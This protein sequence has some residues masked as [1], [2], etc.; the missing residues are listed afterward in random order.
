MISNSDIYL[1]SANL[2][3]SFDHPD[4]NPLD[5]FEDIFANFE[6]RK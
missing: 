3:F 6:M 5:V 4:E 1:N 2:E